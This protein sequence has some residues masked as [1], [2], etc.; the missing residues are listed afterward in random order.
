MKRKIS[1]LLVA[2]MTL[3]LLSGCGGNSTSGTESAPQETVKEVSV[4]TEQKSEPESSQAKD[5]AVLP[6]FL[7]H[8]SSGEYRLLG[9]SRPD[10]AIYQA[11]TIDAAYVAEAYVE[12]LK[13]QGYTVVSEDITTYSTDNDKTFKWFLSHS[14][15][16]ADDV[17]DDSPG[18][19]RV[20]LNAYDTSN[21]SVVSVT[22]SEGITMENYGNE[23]SSSDISNGSGYADCP[24]C[25]GGKCTACNGSK[26]EY[27]YSPGLDREWEECWKCNGTG[28]CSR[29]GGDGRIF[30]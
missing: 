10:K 23:G 28:K 25:Y 16:D 5:P 20:K 8:D 2:I 22:F 17:V 19:V 21:K 3:L 30:G 26:G 15:V 9:E 14:S 27:S 13:E 18:Q 12:L 29:C 6:D 7:A 24:S 11:D 1:R 4:E